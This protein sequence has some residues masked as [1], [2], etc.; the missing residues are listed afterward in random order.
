M[1]PAADVLSTSNTTNHKMIPTE[2]GM[3]LA[4][5]AAAASALSLAAYA[6]TPAATTPPKPAADEDVV[7]LSPFD[8]KESS[9]SGYVPSESMTGS[10]VA[11]KI[12][13]LPYTVNVLNR[14]YFDEFGILELGDNI[15]QVGGFTGLDIGGAFVLRG[16]S[17]SSQLRDGFYRLGRYGS[18][19]I[20]RMEIMKGSN[21]AIYGRTSPGGMLNMISKQPKSKESQKLTLQYGD[22]DQ[23]RGTLETTGPL[24]RTSLG[25]T[26]Y[27]LTLSQFVRGFDQKGADVAVNRNNEAYLAI[28]H[29]FPDSSSL[30]LSAEYFLQVRHA[31]PSQA[32]V[33]VDN[34]GTTDSIN[35]TTGVLTGGGNDV[36][37]GYAKNLADY[38]AVGPNSELNRGNVSFSLVYEKRL[39]RILT[40]RAAGNYFRA[41]RWDFNQNTNWGAITYNATGGATPQ[42]TRGNTPTKGLIFE[43]GGGTQMD[44]L[45]RY[46]TG[47]ISHQS[48]ATIDINDYY[49]YDPSYNYGNTSQ[50][51]IVQW[52]ANTSRVM[53][54]SSD[55]SPIEGID[56]FPKKFQ[57]GEEVITRNTKRRTTSWGG[58]LRH[59]M[60][61]FNDRLLAFTGARFDRVEFRH[62]DFLTQ[63]SAAVGGVFNDLP[64]TYVPGQLVRR[65]VNE[66]KPNVG[67][68]FK[69]TSKLRAFINY[70]ESYFVNQTD[71]VDAIAEADYKSE[72]ADGWDYGFKGDFLDSRL[73]FT[74]SG[75]YANRNNVR[76]TENIEF[77]VGSGTFFQINRRDGDQ[78]VRGAEADVTWKATDSISTGLS[79]GHVNSIFTDFGSS[80]P[81]AKYRKVNNVSPHNGSSYFRWAPTS[82]ALKN[83]SANVG[84]TYVA[85]TRTESPT[86]GDLLRTVAGQRVYVSS[87]NAWALEVPSFTLWSF[88]ARYTLKGSGRNRIDHTFGLNVNNAFDKDYLKVDKRLG[89]RRTVLFTYTIG[90]FGE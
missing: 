5:A 16:F 57:W 35:A 66:L 53:D 63:R 59:Q 11:V 41:R 25:S 60:S 19:N 79:Y 50:A 36:A 32:P 44:L 85:A 45:A 72:V 86:S 87:N 31:P 20:D 1:P 43:D 40:V 69:V 65:T 34:K 8:V 14:E 17:S 12:I 37:L 42:S 33:I 78:L 67:L 29:T 71:N 10:R 55:Y 89:D 26:N 76:V 3:R 15:T 80:N 90:R 24:A 51:D 4:F 30:F 74:V 81:Q 54:L 18:S 22:Y 2:K 75:F 27:I 7:M 28:K 64:A 49:R 39:N 84:V 21:A 23:R 38:N 52:N 13:D 73:S 46:K 68:N 9:S 47:S 56:Y 62:R 83:F 70:S 77:P 82:G 48:L 6:Q 88:G 61:L 58:V